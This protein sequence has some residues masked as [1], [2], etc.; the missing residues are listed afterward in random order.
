MDEIARKSSQKTQ[1]LYAASLNDVLGKSGFLVGATDQQTLETQVIGKLDAQLR[2]ETKTNELRRLEKA[3]T[4]LDGIRFLYH[5]TQED[6]DDCTSS[7]R[8]LRLEEKLKKHKKEILQIESEINDIQNRLNEFDEIDDSSNI[9]LINNTDDN[10]DIDIEEDINN[11]NYKSRTKLNSQE[12]DRNRLIRQGVLTPFDGTSLQVNVTRKHDIPPSSKI[13]NKSKQLKNKDNQNYINDNDNQN[14]SNDNDKDNDIQDV[15]D[16]LLSLSESEDSNENNDDSDFKPDD[17]IDEDDTNDLDEV[18]DD[19]N[20]IEINENNLE[21]GYIKKLEYDDGDEILY[22][23]RLFKWIHKRRKLRNQIEGNDSLI[24]DIDKNPLDELLEESPEGGDA[25]IESSLYKNDNNDSIFGFKKR[26]EDTG[27]FRC[28]N[29]IYSKLFEYQ[30]TCIKWLWELHCQDT[31]GIIGDEMGLGKTIQIISFLAGLHNSGK[32]KK[33]TLIVCPATVMRQWVNEF[34]KWWP[35]FRVVILHSMG[36]AFMDNNSIDYN[37]LSDYDD[38]NDEFNKD[39]SNYYFNSRGENRI[40]NSERRKMK[41]GSLLGIKTNKNKNKTIRGIIH[42]VLKHGHILITT[43]SGIYQYIN[44]LS[45]IDWSYCILDEG[46]KIRNPDA[47]IT[48]ACKRLR[49]NHRLI[50]SGTPIQN[51]LIELWSLFDFVF[52]GRLGTLPVFEAQFAT[53]I[54]LG[55]YANATNVQVQTAYKCAVILR[56]LIGPYLLRRVKAD[57]AVDLPNKTEQVLFCKLTDSQYKVYKD[58]IESQEVDGIL[59]GKRHALYGIDILR[60]IC[61]HPDLIVEGKNNKSRLKSNNDDE[62]EYEIDNSKFEDDEEEDQS[63]KLKKSK[64]R[65]PNN[66][67]KISYKQSFFKNRIMNAKDIPDYGLP[68]RSGKMKVVQI[69]LDLW[70][71]EKDKVLLFCQTRQMMNIME[72]MIK[73]CNYN[74]RRMDGETPLKKRSSLI[75]EFNSDPNIFLFLLTTKV[76]G[77]GINLTGANRIIIFDPDW[78]PSTDMQARERAWRVGQ[79][80][81]VVIYRIMTSGT[82]EEKI[83]HRQIF[84]QFLTNKILKDARQRRF[85]KSNNMADLFSLPEQDYKGTETGDLFHGT[86]VEVDLPI[87]K[88][89]QSKKRKVLSNDNNDSKLKKEKLNSTSSNSKVTNQNKRYETSLWGKEDVKTIIKRKDTPEIEKDSNITIDDD[90]EVKRLKKIKGITK[91]KEFKPNEEDFDDDNMDEVELRRARRKREREKSHEENSKE[92]KESNILSKLMSSD[93]VHS[94]LHHDII[95]DSATPERVIV[96][97]EAKRI[98][99]DALENLKVSRKNIQELQ[100]KSIDSFSPFLPT[101]TGRHGSLGAPE[102]FKKNT[103]ISKSSS[104]NSIA[105]SSRSNSIS[106][107]TYKLFGNNNDT[108]KFGSGS[109][110]TNMTLL[111]SSGKEPLS[112]SSI[113]SNLKNNRE[114]GR[115][116][117]GEKRTIEIQDAARGDG[118]STRRTRFQVGGVDD[119]ESISSVNN[120]YEDDSE[121]LA[122]AGGVPGAGKKKTFNPID[123]VRNMLNNR[124]FG[125]NQSNNV[126]S[127][128]IDNISNINNSL[129]EEASLIERMRQFLVSNGGKAPTSDLIEYFDNITGED[130]ALFRRLLKGIA[131]F[132]KKLGNKD[133]KGMWVLKPEFK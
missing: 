29:S 14:K 123:E 100:K 98:A 2:E 133:I 88:S 111:G 93:A 1:N 43:Y 85:F 79:K 23:R 47:E 130:V 51:N 5:Q 108:N 68:E 115:L 25:I 94:A 65:I 34:H 125:S 21:S 20:E 120:N 116:G 101:W 9:D 80:K 44:E 107:S 30:K 117:F 91:V 53:P 16:E 38:D 83:Y 69:L 49:T 75:D 84:K 105:N 92:S 28:P 61:N 56:D 103:S 52:P 96:E 114:L 97:R 113:L 36:S 62:E 102:V 86:K 48:L 6:L 131:T 128:V 15:S 3:R 57:V 126:S 76:G 64:I 127:N 45:K 10:N 119:N 72:L 95:M 59:N 35:P 77:L 63:F 122:N 66:K 8:I 60:K 26:N 13:G 74:Y 54:N 71:K 99:D 42:H 67:S 89:N 12:S 50:L 22:E 24:E 110:L 33:P 82:I 17:E 104:T 37:N 132:N 31:G 46:H 70:F 27:P 19:D 118:R 106:S 41:Y 55:G 124:V 32:M 87:E 7:A 109:A 11:S 73:N 78:N 81:D 129:S 121:L 40:K 39:N 4:K 112:S 18:D 90:D 58:F